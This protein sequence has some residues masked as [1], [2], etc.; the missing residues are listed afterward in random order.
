M[1]IKRFS[2]KTKANTLTTPM[3]ATGGAVT[4][5]GGYNYHTFSY[6]EG[7]VGATFTPSISGTVEVLVVAGG[8]G[9]GGQVGG[10]GGAGGLIYHTAFS[11][12]AGTGITPSIGRGGYGGRA[13]VSTGSPSRWSGNDA[14]E[15]GA[16]GSDSTFGSMTAVGGGGAGGYDPSSG[17]GN[18]YAQNGGSGGGGGASADTTSITAAGG[19]T[20][21]SP[22]GGTGYG[23]AGGNGIPGSWAGG[24]GGGAGGIGQPGTSASSGTGGVGG[25]GLQ[26]FG[27]WYA[28][29]GSGCSNNLNSRIPGT[30]NIGGRGGSSP[31]GSFLQN[32]GGS[33]GMANRGAGGGGSRDHDSLGYFNISSLWRA[34][35][36]GSGIVVVRYLNY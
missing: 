17:A 6:G 5:S 2:N 13:V 28:A 32:V 8:G 3:S 9:G 19:S 31:S 35:N 21:T 18:T 29:G 30:N 22:S 33:D 27:D 23:F 7:T 14:A 15:R 11:V 36:G 20:Q 26:F 10:G 1:A 16:N 12:T 24:G 25:L 4:T 34:G